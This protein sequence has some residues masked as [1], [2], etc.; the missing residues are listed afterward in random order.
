MKSFNLLSVFV[1]FT[2]ILYVTGCSQEN[3]EGQKFSLNVINGSGSGNYPEGR[4]IAILSDMPPANQ[5]FDQWLGDVLYVEDVRSEA[6]HIVM[7]AQD[8]TVNAS[9]RPVSYEN[10]LQL[11]IDFGTSFQTMQGFG[12]FGGRDVWWGSQNSHHFFNDAWLDQVIGDLGMS[13]W[14]NELYPHNPPNEITASSQ[15]AHW[16]K[17]KPLVQALKSKA[18]EM[19]VDLRIILTA[20][21]PPGAFKWNSWGYSWPGD[22]NA[23][24]GP[25]DQGDFWPERGDMAES[26]NSGSLNPNKYQEFAKWWV[27][28][29]DMYKDIGVDVFAISLQNEPAF[30]QFFNSCF[31]TTHWYAEMINAV[32]PRIKEAYPDVLIFG[33]EHM[34]LNEGRS[35]DFQWFYHQRLKDDPTAMNYIDALAV[36]GYLDGVN[37]S[38]GTELSQYWSNHKREFS[39]PSGKMAWM[40]E[41][42]GYVDAWEGS[43]DKPGA[44]G[45]AIDMATG[46]LFGDVS[47]WVYWQGSALSGIDEFN[48]MSD[49]TKG[50]K[51][52]ASRN[53]YHFI[54]P[55]AVRVAASSENEGVTLL[56]FKHEDHQT[57]TLLVLNTKNEEVPVSLNIEGMEINGPFEI[58]VSSNEENCAFKGQRNADE[59]IVL[60]SRSIVTLHAGGSVLK[61]D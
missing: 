34:L 31:Y 3:D 58:F 35:S 2:A 32:V 19:E 51:Y 40:T 5:E 7:P 22:V 41:T 45:M 30:K 59:V 28:A 57:Q 33:S 11:Q 17:Q 13:M 20:W 50:K 47:A 54:R 29:L 44:F 1:F 36:H 56:A 48:L 43:G 46:I 23:Q 61:R 21:T 12:F 52:Y 55:G 26:N 14:R 25:G 8:I 24:R 38:S 6:T 37:A 49:L 9:Y 27:D 53:Y 60:P 42:S 16:E 10:V 39:E 4:R 18:D 15:D